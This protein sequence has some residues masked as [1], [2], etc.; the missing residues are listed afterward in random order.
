MG[1][2]V[3]YLCEGRVVTQAEFFQRNKINLRGNEANIVL[4]SIERQLFAIKTEAE[5]YGN[6]ESPFIR[7]IVM[8]T[9]DGEYYI[10]P[11]HVE[12]KIYMVIK[13]RERVISI[14]RMESGDSG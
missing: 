11:A 13:A 6:L 7:K 3:E 2:F 5:I 8:Q 10:I 4:T 1:W 14:C 9:A 12:M